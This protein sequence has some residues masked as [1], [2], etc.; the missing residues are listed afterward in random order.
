M[1]YF[2]FRPKLNRQINALRYADKRGQGV[3]Y[4][5][6][7]ANR[8]VHRKQVDLVLPREVRVIS[9]YFFVKKT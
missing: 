7:G 6:Q 1:Y 2:C 9:S 5:A 3:Y 4:N 8:K